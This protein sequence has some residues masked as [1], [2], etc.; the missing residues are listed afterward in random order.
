MIR[1]FIACIGILLG[2]QAPAWGHIVM[3]MVHHNPGEAPTRSAYLDPGYLG[4]IG[5]D[6]KVFFLFDAAQFGI[7][8]NDFDPGIFEPGTPAAEWVQVH[9]DS[10]TAGYDAAK[11]AGLDVY[12]MLDMLVLPRTLVEKRSDLIT[13]SDGKIDISRPYTQL[14]IRHMIRSMFERFPQLDGLVIRTGETYLHDAPYHVGNHPVRRGMDDHITLINLLRDEVC[15]RLDKR[16]IY[17]TWDM[18]QLHTIPHHYLAVTDSI[19]P[20]DNLYFS[21]KHTATD[22]WRMGIQAY[23]PSVD[24]FDTYWLDESGKYGMPFNP[25][26]G[27]GRHKQIV[28]VQCQREYEGKGA[29]PNYVAHGVIDGYSELGSQPGL[30]SLSDL[31]ATGMLHGVWTWSRGGGWG[32]PY[33]P[34]EFWID[35]NARVMAMWA[36][37][38][39][40]T[41]EECFNRVALAKGVPSDKLADFRRLCLLT[42]D[43]VLKGQYSAYGGTYVNWTRDDSMTGDAFTGGYI[44]AIVRNGD[45]DKYIAEKDEA[46]ETWRE[47][48]RLAAAISLPDEADNEFVKVSATYGRIKYEILATAWRMMVRD[49]EN[50]LTGREIDR[51]AMKRDAERYNELWQEWQALKDDHQCC[52]TLYRGISDFFGHDVGLNA[53]VTA[54]SRHHR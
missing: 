21:I 46:V 17:R 35:L 37:N 9:A 22:F 38:P 32:G 11:K 40:L 54:I 43:G 30:K 33:I 1:H 27:K 23:S 18:G 3:D 25:C 2:F 10:I 12:C 44:D 50:R 51:E 8:W 19:E 15:D 14:C 6:A 26:L 28:E 49:R 20:H 4:S 24:T 52:P 5:Y 48:E 41:E 7:D 29:H 34:N 39:S 42:E 53:T 47:I 13:D 16:L 45:A 31:D 36:N